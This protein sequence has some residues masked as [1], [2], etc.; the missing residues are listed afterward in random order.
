MILRTFLLT[1]AMLTRQLYGRMSRNN[2]EE[3][4][5]K[6]HFVVALFDKEDRLYRHRCTGTLITPNYVLTAG[7][8][9]YTDSQ[10]QFDEMDQ[11]I[12]ET[13][14]IRRVLQSQRL[15][16]G[17]HP[18]PDLGLMFVNAIP[19]KEYGQLSAVDYKAISGHLVVYAG[20]EVMKSNC[21]DC[22]VGPMV[23]GEG[24]V[25]ACNDEE[26]KDSVLFRPTP[27]ICAA[28]KCSTREFKSKV[29]GEPG[30]PLFHGGKLVG[31]HL[32]KVLPGSIRLYT[33]ISP[34]LAWIQR[35]I[36]K[37]DLLRSGLGFAYSDSI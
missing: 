16:S 6:Y 2:D 11:P 31:V 1:V 12:N 28:P 29:A 26:D 4:A 9:L 8:C 30:S 35:A 5:A 23:I 27:S 18:G 24:V 36:T 13:N 25:F 34:Y 32:G 14:Y 22:S 17:T 10:V 3:E 37:P 20:F 21:S 15:P 19:M 7:S 33:P